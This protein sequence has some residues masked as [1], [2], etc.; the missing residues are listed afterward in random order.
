MTTQLPIGLYL[1]V[2]HK[3]KNDTDIHSFVHKITFGSKVISCRVSLVFIQNFTCTNWIVGGIIYFY[4]LDDSID[5]VAMILLRLCF[6]L[7]VACFDHGCAV[8]FIDCNICPKNWNLI[9]CCTLMGANAAPL[10]LFLG[11]ISFPMPTK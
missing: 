11:M 4:P 3:S 2:G 5:F 9:V 6:H 7:L 1:V 8:V 10:P